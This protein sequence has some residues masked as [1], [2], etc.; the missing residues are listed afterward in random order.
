MAPSDGEPDGRVVAPGLEDPLDRRAV[1][2]AVAA[3]GREGLDP[4]LVGPAPERVRI[5]AEEAAGGAE[6]QRRDRPRTVERVATGTAMRILRSGNLGKSGSA[7]RPGRA[8]YRRGRA[9]AAVKRAVRAPRARRS[10][11]DQLVVVAV[12]PVAQAPADGSRRRRPGS[13]SDA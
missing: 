4:A 6:R 7:D 11:G 10:G 8:D 12:D 5:D 9:D 2:P 3:G 1:E 13:G